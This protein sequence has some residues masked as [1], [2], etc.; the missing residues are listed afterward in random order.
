[1]AIYMLRYARAKSRC[2]PLQRHNLLPFKAMNVLLIAG[3]IVLAICT[4][5][6]LFLTW[7][8]ILGSALI[9]PEPTGEAIDALYAAEM[10]KHQAETMQR[11]RELEA[12]SQPPFHSL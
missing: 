2:S 10:R 6:G 12:Y 3:A 5:V 11:L 8:A 7:Q 1:M 9:D 4:L